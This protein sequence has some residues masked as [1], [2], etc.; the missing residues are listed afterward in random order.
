VQAAVGKQTHFPI[1][2]LPVGGVGAAAGAQGKFRPA[3]EGTVMMTTRRANGTFV[4]SPGR[5]R[6]ARNRLT[7]RVFEDVLSH[8]NEPAGPDASMTKGMAALEIMMK[9]RPNEYVRAVLSIL[10]KEIAIENVTAEMTDEDL[11]TL[12]AKI[13]DALLTART[14][15]ADETSDDAI[16]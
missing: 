2:R 7:V 13:R 8:W 5:T 6:G 14:T 3:E 1:W 11:D 4:T 15:E 10:P 16:H 9:E 12:M